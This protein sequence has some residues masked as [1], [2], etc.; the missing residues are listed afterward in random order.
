MRQH[1]FLDLSRLNP[2][3][4]NFHLMIDPTE[5]L[6]ISIRQ[7]AS[8]IARSIHSSILFIWAIDELLRRQIIAIQVTSG[9]PITS[10]AQLSGYTCWL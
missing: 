10:N 9:Q 1:R 6:N 8:K 2:V 7:P 3:T 4:P 5:I